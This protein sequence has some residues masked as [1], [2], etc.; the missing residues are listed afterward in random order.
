MVY[1]VP[2]LPVS[3][4]AVSCYTIS[5]YTV[6]CYTVSCLTHYI[7]I[8]AAL[9]HGKIHHVTELKIALHCKCT[10][11]FFTAT[12]AKALFSDCYKQGA[13]V[14]QGILQGYCNAS[15]D[16][17]LFDTSSMFIML[18]ILSIVSTVIFLVCDKKILSEIV[19]FGLRSAS[20][21][22]YL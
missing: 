10:A 2:L 15:Q 5:S 7:M 8:H 6:L 17:L 11:P 9:Y 1:T 12:L 14:L 18:L 4:H 19:Y 13:N 16:M 21:K 20:R 3:F 22:N